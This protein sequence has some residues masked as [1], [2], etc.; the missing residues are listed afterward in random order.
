MVYELVTSTKRLHPYFLG[1]MIAVLT[2]QPIRSVLYRLEASNQLARWFVEL[3]E[4]EIK[5]LPRSSIKAQVLT[6]FVLKCTIPE[7]N[8][9]PNLRSENPRNVGSSM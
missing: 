5:Y 8:P 2:D 1:H 9:M 6:N 4:L 7:E 3:R